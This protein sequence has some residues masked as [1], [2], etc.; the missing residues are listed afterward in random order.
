MLVS[1]SA[2]GM[3]DGSADVP[4]TVSNRIPGLDITKVFAMF[5]VV[6]IHFAFYTNNVA[7]TFLSRSVLSLTV[8][9]VPLFIAVNG[10][11]LF[12]RPFNMRKHVRRT[13]T[14]VVL[15]FLWR[16][17]HLI[18]LRSLGAPELTPVQFASAL[19]G[20]EAEG[21]VLGHFWFLYALV[22]LY[23]LFPL[24][25][26][27]WDKYRRALYP[28]LAALFI[29]YSCVD[30]IRTGLLMV[31]GD[32]YDGLAG[33]FNG[34]FAFTPLF[35]EGYLVLY[36]VGGALVFE[37][38]KSLQ[39]TEGV[40][41]TP[42]ARKPTAFALS[43]V[44]V[45]SLLTVLV[46]QLQYV[47]GLGA[48]GVSYGYW[49]PSTVALTFAFLLIFLVAGKAIAR[50]RLVRVF[51]V[52]GSGTFAVYMMHIPALQ[53]FAQLEPLLVTQATGNALFVTQTAW[54]F[55]IFAALLLVGLLLKRIPFVGRLFVL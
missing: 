21:Y 14:A 39:T 3:L 2:N 48:F 19:I 52:L 36:F 6:Y 38:F 20:G 30:G 49:L 47:H 51:T 35:A 55:L 26:L 43:I 33:I 1:R 5:Q 28:L 44:F 8:T 11:I 45:S 4:R 9:C 13:I 24:L 34:F 17:I 40:T 10:A 31:S 18:V 23:V 27:A 53:L 37:Y 46:K 50:P 12:S 25:K 7:N 15:L 22:R 41:A 32:L 16:A 54:A 29:L 42:P